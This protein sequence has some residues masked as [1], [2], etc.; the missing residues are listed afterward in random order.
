MAAKREPAAARRQQILDAALVAF[1]RRGFHGATMPEICAEAGLSPGTVYRHFRSKDDLIAA[2]AERD[3]EGHLAFLADLRDADDPVAALLA[4]LDTALP[5]FAD[6]TE[7]AL[8][9][10]IFAEAARN[11]RVR[12]VAARYERRVTNALA[13]VLRAGQAA[14]Q[15]DPALD[16][17]AAAALL[18]ALVDGLSSRAVLLVNEEPAALPT[19]VRATIERLLRPV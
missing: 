5:A 2:L 7:A 6:P 19:L 13:A 10:E 9:A 1:A 11:P 8:T 15:I 12:D 4:A 3:L 18:V 17:D 14:G 16:P